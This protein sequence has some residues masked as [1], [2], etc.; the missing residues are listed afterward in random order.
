MVK[1]CLAANSGGHLNELLRYGDFY[2]KYERFF[3]TD[4]HRSTESLQA[5]ERVYFVGKF[6]LLECVSKADF[7]RPLKN[8]FQS[9]R[10]LLR[11]R[12][13]VVVTTG[14]ATAF[15]VGV[16]C[17]LF[18]SRLVFIE[19][20]ARTK[21]PSKFGRLIYPIANLTLVPWENMLRH[22]PKG[23]YVGF[24][25]DLPERKSPASLK[26]IFLTVGTQKTQFNMLIRE[27]D[28]LVEVGEIK[29]KATAQIGGSDYLPR[30]FEYVVY[31]SPEEVKMMTDEA[32]VVVTHGG[33]G[34]ITYALQKGKPVVAVP[35]LKSQGEYFDDHQLQLVGELA[36]LGLIL[37]VYDICDLGSAIKKSADHTPKPFS[38]KNTRV[39]V[40]DRF[41]QEFKG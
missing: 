5:G 19:S 40:L 35:R 2:G 9:F 8:L 15:G 29:A 23:V 24:K 10:I 22:Y 4:G 38:V 26:R 18:G 28:R 30:N 34:S 41:I 12:P 33:V 20:I 7:V 27:M 21:S 39:E 6:I 36:K 16:L 11:E 14:V 1:I 32:D 31:S 3:V 13:D 25:L 17:R 37:P